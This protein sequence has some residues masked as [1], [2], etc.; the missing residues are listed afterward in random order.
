[1]IRL[2]SL[3]FRRRAQQIIVETEPFPGIEFVLLFHG[4]QGILRQDLAGGYDIPVLDALLGEVGPRLVQ[5]SGLYA[6]FAYDIGVSMLDAVFLSLGES[7]PAQGAV[8]AVG[9]QIL[10]EEC[11][12][13]ETDKGMPA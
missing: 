9:A 2:K 11:G 5:E 1:M 4:E 6:V 3:F 8:D 7:F 10:N 13:L 12:M